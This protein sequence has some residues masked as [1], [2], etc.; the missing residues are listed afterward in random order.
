MD[1][2][3]NLDSLFS[4][5]VVV[6]PKTPETDKAAVPKVETPPDTKKEDD[7]LVDDVFNVSSA[8][9]TKAVDSTHS[10]N[11]LQTEL[12]NKYKEDFES[13]NDASTLPELNDAESLF[14]F[15]HNER[16]AYF[17]N[18]L[19][20]LKEELG[21]VGV[22]FLQYVKHGGNPKDF[23]ASTTEAVKISKMPFSS[24]VEKTEVLKNIYRNEGKTE[25]EIDGLVNYYTT[26]GKLSEIADDKRLK[27]I[28]AEIKHADDLVN[29]A[30]LERSKILQNRENYKESITN[31]LKTTNNLLKIPLPTD[32]SKLVDFVSNYTFVDNNKNEYTKFDVELQ[33]ALNNPEHKLFLAYLFMNKFDLG[34]IK[35]TA[36]TEF[37]NTNINKSDNTV[38]T[39]TAT[40]SKSKP[41]GLLD[42]AELI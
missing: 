9:D 19:V 37:I 42:L 5:D 12:F 1:N 3:L 36:N 30:K 22:K 15:I 4:D 8:K 7:A 20:A 17:N 23:I 35:T 29:A 24:L 40:A 13:L 14:N 18:G 28:D 25:D 16:E 10:S 39:S 2:N 26:S 31:T 6:A 32:K 34:F 38:K 33:K 27:A 21:D 11:S 41:M